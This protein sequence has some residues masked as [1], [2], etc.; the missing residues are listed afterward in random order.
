MI[1]VISQRKSLYEQDFLLWSE[2]TAAKLRARDSGYQLEAEEW[3][4]LFH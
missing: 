2:D 3:A 1:E 4:A